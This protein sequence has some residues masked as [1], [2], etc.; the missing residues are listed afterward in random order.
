MSGHGLDD[1]AMADLA[2]ATAPALFAVG[3]CGGK[4]TAADGACADLTDAEPGSIGSD[5]V[6]LG[7]RYVGSSNTIAGAAGCHHVLGAVIERI[8]VDMISYQGIGQVAS[9]ADFP[10]HQLRAPMTG[11]WSPADSIEQRRSGF[12]NQPVYSC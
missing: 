2:V 10:L 12:A 1:E 9:L 11:M 7:I 6:C 5:D 4:S 8:T 3:C